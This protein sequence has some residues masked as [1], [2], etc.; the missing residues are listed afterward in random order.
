MDFAADGPGQPEFIE[1]VYIG[2]E[3]DFSMRTFDI[4]YGIMLITR[5]LVNEGDPVILSI[6]FRRSFRA[7]YLGE[8]Q[9]GGN[10]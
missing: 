4:P 3:I 2:D 7:R 9:A 1:Y 10:F 6:A 5:K 8:W